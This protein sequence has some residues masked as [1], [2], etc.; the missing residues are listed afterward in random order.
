M[1]G[2]VIAIGDPVRASAQGTVMNRQSIRGWPW[3]RNGFGVGIRQPAR[4]HRPTLAPEGRLPGQVD[5]AWLDSGTRC[6]GRQVRERRYPTQR[7]V[8]PVLVVG[9][10]PRIGELLH[11]LRGHE[12]IG[13]ED[14]LAVGPVE[15]FDEGVR[16]TRG[17]TRRRVRRGRCN[18]RA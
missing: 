7:V 14:L 10:E 8:G 9:D 15:P 4:G 18:R 17:G 13:V 6:D 5:H 12:Q 11:F 16:R 2:P 3:S 1:P